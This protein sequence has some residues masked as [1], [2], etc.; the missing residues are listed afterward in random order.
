MFSNFRCLEVSYRSHG[1]SC[2]RNRLLSNFGFTEL[3]LHSEMQRKASIFF[4][5]LSFFR[6][7]AI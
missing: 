6:N 2:D 3:S 7:F 5:F 4:A 1:H